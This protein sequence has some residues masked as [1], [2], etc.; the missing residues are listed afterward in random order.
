MRNAA[1]KRCGVILVTLL[2]IHLMIHILLSFSSSLPS[3]R[4]GGATLRERWGKVEGK[5]AAGDAFAERKYRVPKNATPPR[6]G[7]GLIV[8]VILIGHSRPAGLL[9]ALA[10]VQAAVVPAGMTVH[11]HICVDG[12]DT[13]V[14]AVAR[15]VQDYPKLE[16]LIPKP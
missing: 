7:A 16:T 5:G 8:T 11:L 1:F 14:G 15:G 10:S 3:P 9:S 2:S 12:N 4:D 13:A 6:H